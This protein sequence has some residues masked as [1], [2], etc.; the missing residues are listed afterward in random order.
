M[1]R[2]TSL[3]ITS[4]HA[5]TVRERFCAILRSIRSGISW[6]NRLFGPACILA[7]HHDLERRHLGLDRPRHC[8]QPHGIHCR[9]GGR[10][11]GRA[12]RRCWRPR[13]ER[14]RQRRDSDRPGWRL[15]PLEAVLALGLGNVASLVAHRDVDAA[16]ALDVALCGREYLRALCSHSLAACSARQHS[17]APRHSPR[18]LRS[19]RQ[20]QP[21]A[22]TAPN[23]RS[24]G[25]C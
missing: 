23:P 13:R 8:Y 10:Q 14:D 4:R 20:R 18:V 24:P 15:R 16:V 11:R 9:D 25:F 5:R 3:M 1:T 22:T 12:D 7:D 21:R 2:P 19:R 17:L 6:V